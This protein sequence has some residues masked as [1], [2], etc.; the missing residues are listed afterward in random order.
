MIYSKLKNN[1]TTPFGENEFAPNRH[2]ATHQDA[3]RKR[4]DEQ[5]ESRGS[6]RTA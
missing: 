1:E 3:K 5:M 2:W 6:L 4:H